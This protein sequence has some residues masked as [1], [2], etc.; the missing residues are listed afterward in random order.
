MGQYYRPVC[1]LDDRL[2]SISSYDYD[3]GAKLMEHSYIGNN[4]V[5]A[6]EFLLLPGGR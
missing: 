1:I 6:A 4:F 3:N 5:E 2:E